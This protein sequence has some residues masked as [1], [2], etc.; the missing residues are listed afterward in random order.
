[1]TTSSPAAGPG[2]PAGSA[3]GIRA[4]VVED[5]AD[6]ADVLTRT[7]RRE[8]WDAV[9]AADG[10]AAIRLAREHGPQIVVLDVMLP[11][12]TGLQVLRHLR[13]ANPAVCVLFL[14]ARDSVEDRV[15]GIT[16][17]GDDY[18]TKPFAL[19]EVLARLRGL[20]RRAGIAE[21]PDED[22]LRVGDLVIDEDAHEVW[23]GGDAVELTVTEFELLRY[24][25]RN[26]RRVLSK[27]Q[28]LDR[29]WSYDFGGDA[30]VVELYISY[31]RKK[32][33]R[34]RA[35]DDPHRAG[36]RVRPQARRRAGRAARRRPVT[37]RQLGAR[38]RP[39]TLRARIVTSVA[40]LLVVGFAAIGVI[41]TLVV[42]RVL[43]DR[44]DAQLRAAGTRFS[45]GLE[46][47]DR[48]AD[49][50]PNQFAS[51]EGQATGTL[52]ARIFNGTVTVAAVVGRHFTDQ[53]S[54]AARQVLGRLR[55]DTTPRSVSLPD[56]GTYRVIVTAGRD[57]DLQVT[58]LPTRPV[59]E[60][61]DRLVLIEA[62]VFGV[63]VALIGAA[64]AAL[65]R[66]TLR[67]LGR[68][69]ETAA[70][71]ADLPMASG[72]VSLPDR[73]PPGPP[74][75]EVATVAGAF[76][77]MLEEVES[78]LNE[79]HDSEERLRRFIADASHELRTP[80]AVIRSHADYA[81]RVDDHIPDEVRHALERISAQSERMGHLVEDLLLLA[82]LDSG[83]PLAH[84]DV[85]LTR[86]VLDGVADAKVAGAQHRWQLE[87][88]DTAIAV[89]GDEHALHQVVTNLLSNARAHTPA[90]T[91]V[92]TSLRAAGGEIILTVSDDG[93]GIPDEVSSRVFERFVRGDRVRARATGSSG[94]GL[95]IVGAIVAA[96][97]GTVSLDSTSRG[98]TIT[99]TLPARDA[100]PAPTVLRA[101]GERAEAP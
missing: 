18:V 21:Q 97:G 10:N 65:V 62:I 85:D 96:H 29:V 98:T 2:A 36:R 43:L 55:A 99:V 57:Q 32:I 78:A 12:M 63:A 101:T 60:T 46:H 95:P 73:A 37:I 80:V 34:G 48:D 13:E 23:R 67:P 84:D 1:M 50:N 14:T 70:R 45:V 92:V 71:V 94:L 28:I 5:E 16:A 54:A 53:P 64:S 9:S 7:L 24:L 83:R 41:T 61:T 82:R 11:D 68:V 77:T 100:Q 51:V 17:G 93:P 6:L 33:D 52:G 42:H 86:I 8:G 20:V 19:E 25:M 59:E 30:H 88:P 27:A 26:P 90:G 76:N 39:R 72:T 74:G 56:L 87:L 38:L 49:N 22:G 4:L 91:I 40:V 31:L 58:G 15:A 89:T 81:R 79:R 69:A 66:I 3:T 35:A 75:S 47:N 44:L